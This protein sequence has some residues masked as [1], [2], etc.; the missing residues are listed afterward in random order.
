MTLLFIHK[1]HQSW[2]RPHFHSYIL[3][4]KFYWVCLLPTTLAGRVMQSVVSTYFQVFFWTMWLPT[5]IF[6]MCMDH[7]YKCKN[8]MW[9]NVNV[10]LYRA[11]SPKPLMR[12]G[13]KVR[14]RGLCR[15]VCAVQIFIVTSCILW[16][17]IDG[18]VSIRTSS[19]AWLRPVESNACGHGNV[20]ALT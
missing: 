20:V 14:V 19:S 10:N 11:N 9:C 1:C 17:L 7:N 6:C 18:Q 5:L 12:W 8:L 3:R 13:L 2:W 4:W 15:N 16:L